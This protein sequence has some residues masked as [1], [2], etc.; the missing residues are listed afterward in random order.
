MARP[1]APAPRAADD[2]DPGAAR[3][4]GGLARAN[5]L[6]ARRTHGT[7]LRTLVPVGLGMLALR[8]FVR[9]EQR[10]SG[11][12][13]YVLAW[14]ATETFWKFHGGDSPPPQLAGGEEG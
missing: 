11:A 9:G 14:Y 8:Q 12:P 1:A 7:D 13:W 2:T 6:V 3:V 5:E 10:L 4:L